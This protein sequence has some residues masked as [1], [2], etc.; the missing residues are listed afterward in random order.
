MRRTGD[1]AV[2]L[3]AG[4]AGLLA[5]RVLTE[6]YER[7]TVLDRDLLPDTAEPRRGVPQG[8][9]AH[10]LLPSGAAVI[11]E[12]FPGLLDELEAGGTP[13]V[14]DLAEIRFCPGG[15]LLRL[16]GR[17]AGPPLYQPSRPHLE[18][19][20]RARVRELPGVR[21]LDRCEVTGLAATPRR[22][23]VTGVRT[24]RGGG[25]I[26][27]ADLVV[28][29]TGRGGRTP[30]WLAELGW[31]G[32]PEERLAVDV[33]YATR[34][35]RLPPD[36]P[37][38]KVVGFGARPDRPTGFVLFAQEGDRW[39]LTAFGYGAHHP[40]TDPEGM[41]AF[42]GTV[43]P[44]DVFA[45][46]RAAEPLDDVVTH[47]FPANIR[48]RYDRMRQFPAGLLVVGD[49]VCSSNPAYALG[50]SVAAL[51]AGALRDTLARGDRNLARRF[52]RAAAVPTGRAWQ[53]AVGADLRLPS[54]PE[55]RP[56]PAR[57]V[58]AYVERALT[59]AEHDPVVAERFLRVAALLDP[60][61]RL[62]RPPTVVRV[63]RGAR[64]PAAAAT[65]PGAPVVPVG[66]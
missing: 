41:L 20:L 42:V 53:A 2:V 5:A 17:F 33:L 43:A 23:R 1:H 56:L 10:N 37:A 55:P 35:L 24:A 9:H 66:R 50:M 64:V 7:V 32:P 48:R 40:P 26:L 57:L 34:H 4:V 19:R 45:A 52:F 8:R 44:P 61:P 39:V 14:R 3:G 58:G 49:A 62:L 11:G 30:A 13:V 28:D 18:G 47:R 46:I 12:L 60:F 16:Q 22:D 31:A 63:L 27:G 25:E 21:V 36:A 51:Q 15:H 65:A 59:A 54:V 29:A 38:L 6:T